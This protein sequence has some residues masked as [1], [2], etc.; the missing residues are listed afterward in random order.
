ELGDLKHTV[1]AEDL[2]FIVAD[3]LKAPKEESFEL[4]SCVVTTV[5]GMS[6]TASIRVSF[7]GTEHESVATGNGGFDAFMTA[8]RAIAPQMGIE[9][10]RLAD[11]EVHIPPGGKSDALVQT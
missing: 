5:L 10:P 6:P 2:P 3:V 11:Y 8:L 9:I 1:T 4:K 7:R